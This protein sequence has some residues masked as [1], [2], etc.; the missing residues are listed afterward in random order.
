MLHMLQKRPNDKPLMPAESAYIP[1]ES[2]E[3]KKVIN[4]PN[5]PAVRVFCCTTVAS[6]VHFADSSIVDVVCTFSAV[7]AGVF[8][9]LAA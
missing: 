3:E 8:C 4:P 6:C 2:M 9:G 1:V 5:P 7:G